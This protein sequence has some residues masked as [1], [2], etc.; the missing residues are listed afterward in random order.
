MCFAIWSRT[1]ANAVDKA[2]EP[3]ALNKL[4]HYGNKTLAR[5]CRVDDRLHDMGR[6]IGVRYQAGVEGERLNPHIEVQKKM[7]M[8]YVRGLRSKQHEIWDGQNYWRTSFLDGA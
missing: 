2:V 5:S 8:A 1:D 3:Q 7:K 6:Q 4:R